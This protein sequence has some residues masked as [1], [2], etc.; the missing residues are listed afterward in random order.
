MNYILEKK[1]FSVNMTKEIYPII[2]KKYGKSAN[3]VYSN[4]KNTYFNIKI[5]I[6]RK[7]LGCCDN[8]NPTIKDL[9][10]KVM[11]KIS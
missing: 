8:E 10:Y 2:G 7:Y 11:E 1:Q 3:T 4:I 6:L 5:D 9:M